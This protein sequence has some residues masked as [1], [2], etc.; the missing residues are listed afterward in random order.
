MASKLQVYYL[1]ILTI[2]I[3]LVNTIKELSNNTINTDFVIEAENEIQ[4]KELM[5]E[6]RIIV[7]WIK[8][9]PWWPN[10]GQFFWNFKTTK[11]EKLKFCLKAESI[12]SVCTRCVELELPIISIND[13]KNPITDKESTTI[14]KKTREARET[15]INN[16]NKIIDEE[17]QKN[18]NIMDD[19]KK[20]KIMSVIWE[21]LNDISLLENEKKE[22]PL[23]KRKKLHDLKELL[24][25]I[26]MWS[27]LEKAISVLEETFV[28]MEDIETQSLSQ[29]KEEEQKIMNSSVVS[30]IDIISELEKLKRA[31]QTNEAGTKKNSS[32][33]YYTYLGIVWLY[34][35]FIVKDVINK[36]LQIR[37]I[38]IYS[39]E[40]ISFWITII[41]IILWWVF[42]YHLINIT[43]SQN[44]LLSMM[45][46]WIIGINRE[47][48][49]A[50]RKSSFIMSIIYII[51]AI[52]ISM[53]IHRLLIVNFALV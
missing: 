3:Y 7:L 16:N 49:L 30:N 11:D 37:K 36:L 10:S 18:K 22:I 19:K 28:L 43:L 48:P 44:I 45:M 29:M 14:I 27:N 15:I 34:Q 20:E 51:L 35:K 13:I 40:Y 47:L 21:T 32:D 5:N 38:L 9:V 17:L 31:N 33:L 24:T 50:V 41:S 53:I 2:M 6:Y 42:L 12:E 4:I 1:S 25:K 23:E 46:V 8:K 39:I 26:K 52:I